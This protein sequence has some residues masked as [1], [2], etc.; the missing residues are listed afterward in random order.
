MDLHQSISSIFTCL[1]QQVHES[2]SKRR[3]HAW[4]EL[5]QMKKNDIDISID[6]LAA[7][8]AERRLFVYRVT[9]PLGAACCAKALR[10]GA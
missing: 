5:E 4:N 9:L 1:L 3:L 2:G 10:S 8:E 7:P 6:I